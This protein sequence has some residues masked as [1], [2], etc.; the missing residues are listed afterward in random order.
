MKITNPNHERLD[1]DRWMRTLKSWARN[2]DAHIV[3]V[4]HPSKLPEASFG[5]VTRR[6]L[7]GSSGISQ[8]ADNVLAL[9]RARG[10][11]R[12]KESEHVAL[13]EGAMELATLKVRYELAREGTAWFWYSRKSLT[14]R[15][16][17]TGEADEVRAVDDKGLARSVYSKS[18]RPAKGPDAGGHDSLSGPGQGG[19]SE[20]DSDE[21][22]TIHWV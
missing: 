21:S 12:V 1:I 22:T 7:K 20:T 15:D 16:M 11:E 10:F 9:Y 5:R 17:S 13:V 2:W 18:K 14:Y 3:V 19:E 6:D 4:V 8:E